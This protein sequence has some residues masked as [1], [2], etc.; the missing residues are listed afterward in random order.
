MFF[1]FCREQ[2]AAL[3]AAAG[4]A[5][6]IILVHI[7]IPRKNNSSSQNV[8]DVK[9]AKLSS[10][11]KEDEGNKTKEVINNVSLLSILNIKE[12][13]KLL[14]LPQVNLVLLQTE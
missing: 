10:E 5:F 11:T 6:S 12:V 3:L 2:S 13:L 8:I 7:F 14:F 9:N 4:S 1:V